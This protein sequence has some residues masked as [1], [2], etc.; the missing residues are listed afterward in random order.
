MLNAAL[1][2][3]ILTQ[4]PSLGQG[5]VAARQLVEG[6]TA[7]V[8]ADAGPGLRQQFGSEVALAGFAQKLQWDFGKELRVISEG[9]SARGELTVYRRVAHF[10]NYARGMV[11]ELAFDAQGKVAQVTSQV[12]S[13]AA[14]TMKDAHQTRANLRL[15]FEGAWNVLWGGHSYGDNPHSAVPDQRFA[16]DLLMFK[17]GN[18]FQ[19]DGTKVEH[20][21]CWGLP[22]KSPGDGVVVVAQDGVPDNEPNKTRGGSL[23]GNYVVIDHGTGEYSLIAHMQKG[24]LR[25]KVGDHLDPGQLLGFTGNSGMSTEP[26]I[27]YQLMDKPDWV[28]ADGLPAQFSG[29][30]AKGQLIPRGEPRRGEVISPAAL[31]AS[32]TY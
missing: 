15:P 13:S 18:T 9:L 10:S 3:L 5:R 14:P 31:E 20:Y 28:T 11:L 27:H 24:S 16:L 26:H 29:Y 12:A 2:C 19:G 22:V 6:K 25:V 4:S 17:G 7:A 1:L 21:F 8:W 30:F 23:Y 32:N